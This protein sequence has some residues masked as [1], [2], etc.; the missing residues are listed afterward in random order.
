MD[1]TRKRRV[2][3]SG[4]GQN[5]WRTA[6]DRLM[7]CIGGGS[8]GCH[9]RRNGA[10]DDDSDRGDND[11]RRGMRGYSCNARTR[12]GSS[13]RSPWSSNRKRSRGTTTSGALKMRLRY[14]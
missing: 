14:G 4:Y 13:S 1:R 9:R 10:D 3:A 12:S 6:A 7:S 8:R 5:Q 11:N 2:P